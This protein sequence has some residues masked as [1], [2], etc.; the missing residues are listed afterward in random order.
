MEN[1]NLSQIMINNNQVKTLSSV[2]CKNC[3]SAVIVKFGTYKGVQLYYCKTCNRK[4]KCDSDLFHMKTSVEQISSTLEMYYSGSSVKDIKN[5]LV[6]KYQNNRSKQTIFSWMDKYSHEAIEIANGY[7]PEVGERWITDETV[8]RIAGQNVWIYD[9]LDVKTRFLLA[10]R[11]ALSRTSHNTE[12]LMKEASKHAG[13]KIPEV[14][15]MDANSSFADGI[16]K[17]FGSN[18]G[19][20]QSKSFAEKDDNQRMERWHETLNERTKIIKRLK[21]ID[22]ATRVIN[23]FLVS[24]NFFKPHESSDAKT[25]AETANIKFP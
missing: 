22:S 10:T 11:M 23:G 21:T 6:Q 12:M 14:V 18:A 8:V 13:G 17:A 3:G 20:I 2:S 19:H 7:H 1:Q 16:E 15:I 9:I 24:Y 4:F 25:P 5:F